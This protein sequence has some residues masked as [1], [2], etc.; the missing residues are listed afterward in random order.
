M[1]NVVLAEDRFHILNSADHDHH[2]G[3][4][5]PDYEQSDEQQHYELN[6]FMHK[7]TTSFG[8]RLIDWT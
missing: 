6:E 2:N 5:G 8:I 7:R 3:T 4:Y 1:R